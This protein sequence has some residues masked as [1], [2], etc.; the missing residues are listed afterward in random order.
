MFIRINGRYFPESMIESIEWV[1]SK[2]G[3]PSG[4]NI[5]F[6]E[7]TSLGWNDLV[8]S[9]SEDG[10]RLTQQLRVEDFDGKSL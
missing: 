9:D 6:R 2:G 10:I 7:A 3:K 1:D 4:Y 5:L 8:L